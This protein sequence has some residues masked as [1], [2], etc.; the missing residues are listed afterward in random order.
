LGRTSVL[1]PALTIWP[2]ALNVP[3]AT[4]GAEQSAVKQ[5]ESGG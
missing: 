2:L 4:V 3:A 5:T 1:P